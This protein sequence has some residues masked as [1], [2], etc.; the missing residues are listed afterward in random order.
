MILLHH[1]CMQVALRCD[2]LDYNADS[3]HHRL[4]SVS[5]IEKAVLQ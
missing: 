1:L 3:I 5:C 4:T 2:T